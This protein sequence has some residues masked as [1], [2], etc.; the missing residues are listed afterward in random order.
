MVRLVGR[1]RLAGVGMLISYALMQFDGGRLD[2]YGEPPGATRRTATL[3]IYVGALD[4][5]AGLLFPVRT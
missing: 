5:G 4:R 1:L 3:L 2:G